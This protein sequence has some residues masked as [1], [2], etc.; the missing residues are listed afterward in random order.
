MKCLPFDRLHDFLLLF[1]RNLNPTG[2]GITLK[3]KHGFYM[4]LHDSS[5]KCISIKLTVA[6]Y[7]KC[8]ILTK[9]LFFNGRFLFI[10][11]R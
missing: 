8:K 3:L 1:F 5:L 11:L 10:I 7:H 9:I 4:I 2:K 6:T